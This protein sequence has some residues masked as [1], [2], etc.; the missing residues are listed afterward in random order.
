MEHPADV[1]S[2]PLFLGPDHSVAQPPEPAA[3]HHVPHGSDSSGP[4]TARPGQ[5]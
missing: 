1:A 2:S 5:K 4:P 3:V